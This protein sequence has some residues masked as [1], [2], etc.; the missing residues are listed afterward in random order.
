MDRQLA[1]HFDQEKFLKSWNHSKK[2]VQEGERLINQYIHD[3]TKNEMQAVEDAMNKLNSKLRQVASEKQFIQLKEKTDNYAK[4]ME[5]HVIKAAT[6]FEGERRRIID[7]PEKTPEEKTKL[8][9]KIHDY[10]LS[11]MYTPDEQEGFK[12]RCVMLLM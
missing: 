3:K 1:G 5:Q 4:Q 7:D 9:G 8:I 2:G 11:K 6:I 12:Q 10:I